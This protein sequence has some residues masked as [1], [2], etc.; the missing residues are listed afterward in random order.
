MHHRLAARH[1]LPAFPYWFFRKHILNGSGF[2]D[3]E[4]IVRVASRRG[5]WLIPES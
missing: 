2:S 5:G 1:G 4:F 3:Q